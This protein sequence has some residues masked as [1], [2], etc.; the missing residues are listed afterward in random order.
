[1]NPPSKVNFKI[2]QG[3]TFT[4]VLRKE[5]SIIQYKPIT[6]ISKTAPIVITSALHVIPVGWRVKVTNVQGMKEINSADTYHI[7]T[8]ATANN[9][10][11]NNVNAL[12]FSDYI[13]GGVIEL[14]APASLLGTTARMQLRGKITDAVPLD[15][16]T[17]ENSKIL[18]DDTAKT[19]T[20]LVNAVTTA[21]YTF[22]NAIYA[23]DLI[24]GSTITPFIYGNITVEKSVTR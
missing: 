24:S 2:Y 16:Y 19:I 18:I 9:V 17:T 6:A 7:V 23:M 21:A 15:E 22:T 10:T 14:N 13:S 3:S 4:E 5:S 20:I 12:G 1:M 8:D 11:F